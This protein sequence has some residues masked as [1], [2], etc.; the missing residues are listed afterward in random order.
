MS[1]LDFIE[2]PAL[3]VD[4]AVVHHNLSAMAHAI[5]DAGCALR[6]HIKTHKTPELAQMQLRYGARGITCAK[7][8]EAEVM[9]NGGLLD[10][11]IA[12]PLVG[13]FRIA[14]A[15]AL[16]RRVRLIL[17]TDSLSGAQAL[18]QGAQRHGMQFEV[19]LEVDTGL[20]RTGA[21]LPQVQALAHAVAQLPGLKLTGIFTF[22]GLMKDGVPSADRQAA[23]LQE[24]QMLAELAQ[25]LRTAGLD[26]RDVSCGS[27][28]TGAYAAQAEGVTEVRPGTYIFY[29]R[30]QVR[31][32]A[33][34]PQD[35]AAAVWV[36]V[37]STPRP[38]L[39][40]VDG[41][42]KTFGTDF[43][44][45]AAPFYFEGY[46]VAQEN[47]DLVLERVNEEHGMLRSRGGQTS[48]QVGDRLAI[49]PT[50]ICTTVNLHDRLWLL[51]DDKLRSV[52]VA[53]RGK[54]V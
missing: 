24:G 22:R 53:A 39:A 41:G 27:T 12:Y 2:T 46:G 49:V 10:I 28:P 5:N 52:P 37:V 36:T 44:P 14:R 18:S 20:G 6:P 3:V 9:A 4:M 8:S 45:G 7:V 26:I 31:E 42:S 21:G 13:E 35:C 15:A 19:R 33:C 16:A 25:K 32:G 54:L 17:A 1:E 38:D 48:L 11:F 47:D 29:D 51:E 23:G 43:I 50:H 30:M 34:T 40:I